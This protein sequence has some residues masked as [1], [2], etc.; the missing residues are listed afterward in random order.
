MTG[1]CLI[2]VANDKEFIRTRL[3]CRKVKLNEWT[4]SQG[5]CRTFSD[6]PPA[7]SKTLISFVSFHCQL[8]ERRIYSIGKQL[9]FFN[10]SLSVCSGKMYEF[11]ADSFRRQWV[12]KLLIEN[13]VQ[14]WNWRLEMAAFGSHLMSRSL[15]NHNSTSK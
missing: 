7:E 15:E 8:P 2:A 14:S 10:F 13:G 4:S 9:W 12:N 5:N 11:R 3:S 6:K 1:S